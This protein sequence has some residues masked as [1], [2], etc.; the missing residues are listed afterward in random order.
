MSTETHVNELLS[1]YALGCLDQDE[2]ILV[3]EHLVTCAACR[4]ELQSYQTVVDQL[5]WAAPSAVPPD[6]LK[7]RLMERIQPARPIRAAEPRPSWWEQLMGIW[8][9]VAPAWGVVSLL[10]IVALAVGILMSNPQVDEHQTVPGGMRVVSL[11]GTE[12][13][14][15]AVGT[16]VISGDGEYGALVVDGLPAL[17]EAQQYQL[18]LIQDGQRTSGGVFSVNPE[19]YG[20]LW[21]ASPG[22]LS[23]YPSFGITVEPAGGSPGPTGDKVLGGSL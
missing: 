8:Q 4:V 17:G 22:P 3:S 13:T 19:G 9:R 14:P 18:W 11:A 21:I 16:I 2:E 12:V 15:A 5:A 1:A 20:T 7:Q 10:L 23:N 6:R